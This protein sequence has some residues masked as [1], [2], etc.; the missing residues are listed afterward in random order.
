LIE[1][2]AAHKFA[3]AIPG[4]QLIVYPNV[5]HLPQIEIP[6]RSAQDVERFLD[7]QR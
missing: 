5:G 1:V 4:A 6:E 7:A 3:D 2:K